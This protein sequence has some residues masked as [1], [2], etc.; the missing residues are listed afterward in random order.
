MFF[1]IY[2]FAQL[3]REVLFTVLHINAG[4]IGG[5]KL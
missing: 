4:S 1:P 3:L 2:A 5:E